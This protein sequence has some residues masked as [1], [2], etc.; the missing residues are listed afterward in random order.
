MN[1]SIVRKSMKLYQ[2]KNYEL[3]DIVGIH[4]SKVASKL[5]NE[6]PIQEQRQIAKDI[7]KEFYKRYLRK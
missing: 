7:K 6:L 5:N 2:V 1:N 4:P 3:A